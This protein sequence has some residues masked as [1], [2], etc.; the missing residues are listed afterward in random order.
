[1]IEI[2]RFSGTRH[3]VEAVILDVLP[4]VSESCSLFMTFMVDSIPP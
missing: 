1:M 2:E 4:S 3:R